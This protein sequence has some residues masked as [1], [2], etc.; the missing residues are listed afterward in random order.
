MCHCHFQEF[1]RKVNRSTA[2]W[3]CRSHVTWQLTSSNQNVR[4]KSELVDVAGTKN[5]NCH[6]CRHRNIFWV[7]IQIAFAVVR[8]PDRS[9]DAISKQDNYTDFRQ[10]TVTRVALD[11]FSIYFWICRNRFVLKRQMTNCHVNR[12]YVFTSFSGLFC[13]EECRHPR[14]HSISTMNLKSD[15]ART[16]QMN[17]C[18]NKHVTSHGIP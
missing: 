13:L 11:E 18:R 16:S 14:C 7:T 17:S 15:I 10:R 1:E 2:E 4:P 6:D 9:G 8:W 12:T 3:W 5:A